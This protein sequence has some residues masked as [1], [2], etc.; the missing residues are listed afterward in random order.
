MKKGM[1]KAEWLKRN[2]RK[3]LREHADRLK[4]EMPASE[5]WFWEQYRNSKLDLESDIPNE[6]FCGF[7]PDVLNRQFKYVIEVQHALHSKPEQIKRDLEKKRAYQK[8][9][10]AVFYVWA[11]REM[12]FLKF[13]RTMRDYR[14]FFLQKQES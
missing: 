12:S 9:G 11:W 6:P 14:E 5:V 8:A 3:F 1:R 13:C 4:S 2:K 7:I 10:F